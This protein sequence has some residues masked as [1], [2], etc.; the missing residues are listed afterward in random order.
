MEKFEYTAKDRSKNS[1][2]GVVEARNKKAAI[3][4]VKRKRLTQI[5]VKIK[6]DFYEAVLKEK[7]ILGNII[8]QDFAGNIQMSLESTSITGREIIIFTKQL[9]TMLTSG[10]PLLESLMILLKQQKS[11]IMIRALNDSIK[12]IESGD[13]LSQAFAQ[14]PKIFDSLYISMLTAGEK[15][16][17]L[18]SILNKLV[19]Y[20]ERADKLKSQVKAALSY[21]I[22]VTVISLLVVSGLL[23]YV[24]PSFAEQFSD[25]GKKLPELTQFVIDASDYFADNVVYIFGSIVAAIVFFVYWRKTPNGA[26]I[27]DRALLN[28]PV[29][30]DMFTKIS[31]GRF[32]STL[33][34]MLSSGVN[35]LEA[36]T[37]CASSAGNKIIEEFIISSKKNVEKG[38]KLSD[39]LEGDLIPEMVLSMITIGESTGKLDEMLEKVS[40]FYEEEIDNSI[41]AMVSLIEPVMIVILGGLVGFIVVAMYLPVFEMAGNV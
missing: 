26:R 17:Q 18:D 1:V 31:I 27:I 20:M 23:T 30:G 39:S 41:K 2:K 11:K 7:P 37:I 15:S 32:S 38:E 28:F 34:S 33:S 3:A 29:L 35:L 19:I 8:Y 12:K 25:A 5:S 40:A 36:L 22:G 10:I 4:L 24:V 6:I 14:H 13:T 21:P 16:G 9:S